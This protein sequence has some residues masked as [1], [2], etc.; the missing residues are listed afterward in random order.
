METIDNTLIRQTIRLAI[1]HKFPNMGIDSIKDKFVLSFAIVITTALIMMMMMTMT[2][3]ASAQ[4]SQQQ[5]NP[6]SESPQCPDGY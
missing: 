4:P 3:T 6:T 1:G 5:R 2:T